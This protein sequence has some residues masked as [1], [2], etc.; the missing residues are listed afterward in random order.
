MRKAAFLVFMFILL[1]GYSL[2][3]SGR[4]KIHPVGYDDIPYAYRW[5]DEFKFFGVKQK[6]YKDTISDAEY[7]FLC[8]PSVHHQFMISIQK[9]ANKY[10]ITW[11]KSNAAWQTDS[12]K[13]K[14]DPLKSKEISESQWL[15]F[16]KRVHDMH[17]WRMVQA[18]GML[19]KADG[20][21]ADSDNAWLLEGKDKNRYH[22]ICWWEPTPHSEKLHSCLKYMLDLTGMK[23]D[24][25]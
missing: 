17:F 2:G 14:A 23:A 5:I 25:Y 21:K 1:S 13:A 22:I 11:S 8:L 16:I 24:M 20:N 4:R 10:S 6:L 19:F 7:R 18:N 15:E 9:K 12:K 3:Q